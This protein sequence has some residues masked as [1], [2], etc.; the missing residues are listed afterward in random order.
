MTVLKQLSWLTANELM[1]FW[2]TPIAMFFTLMFPVAFLVLSMEV[3]IPADAPKEI[4]VNHVAPS[5]MV[6][7]MSSTAI[8]AVPG[9]IASYRQ[10]KFLKRLKCSP[11]RPVAILGSLAASSFTVTVAGIGLLIVA[12]TLLYG[13]RLAGS[14]IGL[15][16]AFNL[17]FWSLAATFLFISAV[18]R[19]ERT[20]ATIAQIVFFPVMFLSGVAIPIERLPDWIALYISP[21]IPVTHAVELMQGA[22][23]GAPLDTLIVPMIALVAFLLLGLAV[24][25]YTFRWE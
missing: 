19:S 8:Y 3:F 14:Y 18:T 2:R 10:S 16:G 20:S 17:A 22:W 7:I 24:A 9:T 1:L 23:S 4:V 12:A 11:A 6:L 21:F 5:L 15:L 13:A 25:T